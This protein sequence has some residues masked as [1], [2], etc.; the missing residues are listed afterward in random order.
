M[1]NR[2]KI[3]YI[4]ETVFNKDKT[5]IKKRRISKEIFN[6]ALKI[7]GER[8]RLAYQRTKRPNG[9]PLYTVRAMRFY[10]I[11]GYPVQVIMDHFKI[12]SLAYFLY[13]VEPLF[14][15][16]LRHMKTNDSALKYLEIKF[17]KG[18]DY[19]NIALIAELKSNELRKLDLRKLTKEKIGFYLY[20]DLKQRLE[21]K[22]YSKDTM[23]KIKEESIYY[24]L[25]NDKS[26]AIA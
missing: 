6:Y 26:N 10:Y 8:V 20:K 1:I 3:S 9:E 15:N 24:S 4:F 25:A 13:L 22:F 23:L 18:L 16:S 2:Q 7:Y 11:I 14:S 17:N 12:K 19:A 21:S 5:H